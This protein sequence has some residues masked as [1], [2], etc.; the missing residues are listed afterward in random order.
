MANIPRFIHLR[1][2]TE[3]SL[4]EGAVPVKKLVDLCRAQSMPAVAITDTNNMFAALE[5]SETA[6]SAGV[7]PIIGCQISVAY[8]PAGPGE[9][10]RASATIVLLAQNEA[11]YRGL[12]KLNSCL[13]LDKAG[14]LP[15]VTIDELA[16]HSAG[17]I[18]GQASRPR[19]RP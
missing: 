9:K 15:E 14:A 2:H 5:F 17:I 19:P 13:Y 16:H 11:G 4:L 3:H 18:S 8:D 6:K 12:M 1:V 7:Q 10:P